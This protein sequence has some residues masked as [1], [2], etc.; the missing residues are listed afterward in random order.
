MTVIVLEIIF[1]VA[2]QRL[3]ELCLARRNTKRL[4]ARGGQ[5]VGATHYPLIIAIHAGWLIALVS[6]APTVTQ[7]NW[8]LIGAFGLFQLGRVWVLT[9]LGP[10]WTTR[11][12]TIPNALLVQHGPY[13]WFRHPNYIIV[14]GE[15]LLL[16]LAFGHLATALV[17]TGLNAVVLIWRI[18]TE[19]DALLERGTAINSDAPNTFRQDR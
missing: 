3:F 18:R 13:R 17:F 7:I 10:Y 14:A 1:L 15:I 5:E 6:Q 16:P 11:I 12:I 19:N 8:W 9:S 4:M 2:A